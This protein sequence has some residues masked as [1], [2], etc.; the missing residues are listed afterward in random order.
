MP[1]FNKGDIIE[2]SFDPTVGHEPA[3]RRPDLGSY[4]A[5]H[6]DGVRPP[7]APPAPAGGYTMNPHPPGHGGSEAMRALV[8][9]SISTRRGGG[10]GPG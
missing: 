1:P 5:Y 10:A 9:S 2:V 4:V 7:I 3:K 6:A 8:L